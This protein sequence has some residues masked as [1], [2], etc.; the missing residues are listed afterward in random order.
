[1]ELVS[2]VVDYLLLSWT[3]IP[4]IPKNYMN[5]RNKLLGNDELVKKNIQIN[6]QVVAT[7]KVIFLCHVFDRGI[8]W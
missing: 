4:N 1:M 8:R 6:I 7:S 5:R 2:K 3:G